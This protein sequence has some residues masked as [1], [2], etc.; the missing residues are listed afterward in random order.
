MMWEKSEKEEKKKER[1]ELYPVPVPGA[2]KIQ[3][4]SQGKED[5]LFWLQILLCAAL[6][7]FVL[8]SKTTQAPYWTSIQT[9]YKGVLEKGVTFSS[10][11]TFSHFADQVIERLRKKAQTVLDRLDEEELTGQGGIW[12]IG[13]GNQTPPEGTSLETYTMETSFHEPVQGVLT[14]GY[15]FRDH[16]VDGEEDFHAGLDIAAAEGTAIECAADG[17][18][19]RTGYNAERGNYVIVRHENGVQTLYQ[20]MSCIFVR[21]GETVQIEQRLGTVGSTGYSTGP[22]LHFELIVNGIR[23][24]PSSNFPELFC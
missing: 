23:M 3:N 21:D 4:K 5:L 22:H 2:N 15:G 9:E 20:H 6:A 7:A 14:S 17:Q 10:E 11:T 16:P 24:D 18:V 8:F 13:S 19:M 1:R 12:K